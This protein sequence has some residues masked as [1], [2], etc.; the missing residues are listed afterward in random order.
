MPPCHGLYIRRDGF[1]SHTKHKPVSFYVYIIQSHKDNSYYKGSTERPKERLIEHNAG[2]S[3]YTSMR[4][5]WRLVYVEELTS[6]REMLIREKRL[7]RGNAEYYNALIK[8]DRNIV[9][10]F[11]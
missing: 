5:P 1:E 8:S 4:L 9:N 7:K 3:K 10:R 6:K 2:L 11:N